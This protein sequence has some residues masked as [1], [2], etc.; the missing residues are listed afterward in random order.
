MRQ[1]GMFKNVFY[2][3]F[4]TMFRYQTMFRVR[5]SPTDLQQRSQPQIVATVV[6][7]VLTVQ[8]SSKSW[9]ELFG[10]SICRLNERVPKMASLRRVPGGCF[11]E[12]FLMSHYFCRR[13]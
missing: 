12:L 11:R 9:L 5:T 7:A 1:E 10:E 2:W 8:S 6:P 3:S 13:Y 4:L